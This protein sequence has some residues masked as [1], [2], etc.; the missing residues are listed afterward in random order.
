MANKPEM[1]TINGNWAA[2]TAAYALSEAAA[3]YPIT[4]SSDMAEYADDWASKGQLNVYGNVPTVIEM[5]SEAGA[6]GTLHGMLSGGVLGTTFTASQGLLL[7]IPNMYKMVGELLPCVI[8]VSARSLASHALSIF[9]DH[10]DIYSIR[11]TGFAMLSSNSVQEVV[12]LATVAHLAAVEASYPFLHFFD[13]FR[14]SH[15][16]NKVGI[17]TQDQFASLI[18]PKK[19]AEFKARALNP[20]HP[21]QQ[22]TAQNP[23]TYF[24]NREACNKHVA[25]L[26]SIV[27][28]MMDKVAKVTGRKYK[29]FDY[30]GA[31][32]ATNVIIAMGSGCEA[33]DQ[34]VE[35]LNKAG[36]KL[37]LIKV[38]LYRPFSAQH[39]M[40][41]IPASCQVL[42]ILDRAKENG[43]IGEPLYSDVATALLEQGRTNLK[44]LGG[45][46]GLS[47]KEF[48]PD[49][50]A[51][52]YENAESN[53]PKNHFSVGINDDV[54]HNSL[55]VTA[56]PELEDDGGY[57]FYGLGSDG[58]VG[59]NRNSVSI[60][61]D[62]TNLYA[63]AYFQ[64][65]S[66][67][68]GSTTISHL[69]F[70][71]KPIRNTYL[72]KNPSFVACHNQTFLTR[73]DMLAGIKTG[74][75]FLLNTTY[76]R[77]EIANHLPEAVVQ[78]LL[79]KKI[80][81]YIINAYKIAADIGMRGRVNTIMQSAFFKLTNVIPYE[82]AK[83]YMK[84]AIDKSYGKKGGAVLQMNYKAVDSADS[85]LEKVSLAAN[86]KGF[87][88]AVK[89]S[90]N[91]YFDEF[92]SPIYGLKGNNLPVS[93]F[94]PDG[95]VP[96]ATSQYEK[97][98]IATTLPTWL[99]EHCIQCNQCALVCPHGCLRPSLAT[100]EGLKN[101][102]ETF[103]TRPA[104][105][106]PDKQYRIQL[107]PGDCTGCGMCANVCPSREKALVME[108]F[109]ACKD[110]DNYKFSLTLPYPDV[111]PTNI[112]NSQFLKPY[113]EFSGACAGCGETPYIKLVSQ[114]F[115]KRMIVAN[116]TGCTSI[117]S[118][119]SP[120]C[121][122][123]T[124]ADGHGPAWA[125]SLFE[126][127]AE[128]GFGI[129]G[130][131]DIR[132]EEAKKRVQDLADNGSDATAKALAKAYLDTYEDATANEAATREMTAYLKTLDLTKHHRSK[133]ILAVA[134]ALVK[135]SIWCIGG[136]GWAYDIGFGGLDHVIANNLDVNLLV[137][138][139]EVYSNTG[140]QSSK[141]TPSGAIAKFAAG[142]KPT[143]KKDL[144]AI[145]M[146]YDNVYIAQI[147][148]GANMA[149]TL[150]ALKEA[151]AYR[152][153]SL[154]IAYS[155]CINHGIDMS[156]G[157][158]VMK[159]AVEAGYWTLF[160]R[161]AY[162]E[163]ILDSKEPTADYIEFVTSETRYK[164]LEG[165]NPAAAKE[166]FAQGAEAA[167]KRHEKYIKIAG[168]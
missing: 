145:A 87:K 3:I 58:T 105:G 121:P 37:G 55:T 22:G 62:N 43:A 50:V 66:K 78:T 146:N 18:N 68:S 51:A 108:D 149:Q 153:P 41:A 135:K 156:Q 159:N 138:D 158:K 85:C 89:K 12:D 15:E 86:T 70:S 8:H 60:V 125:N 93:A 104:T 56:R 114:L 143:N 39:L 63:Q 23:D 36:A 117:Y 113:F 14:T 9:G 13:G 5:Q 74:G 167:K 44:I 128:F 95:R 111:T 91:K 54:T 48:T 84:D 92:C 40:A 166:L 80:N 120:S 102:P 130:A 38:R 76:S 133:A 109:E 136:D 59:A 168:K 2:S 72:V 6:A 28:K 45:R 65:D 139:T 11:P 1:Q 33:I 97:R 57:K 77:D 27:Q 90:G 82:T 20:E 103:V 116:A 52:I 147:A 16:F 83:Q 64:Y 165:I 118:G 34:T 30:V 17:I 35:K 24:Q 94:S 19:I 162:G 7:M 151:E 67:K 53:S 49:M 101:A 123:T 75:T 152:G 163:L 141:A 124:D 107:S 4:P 157:M 100:T 99:P 119:S 32:D 96:T 29:L 25:A 122:Y 106:F 129:A 150:T 142:G 126:D 127:N 148:M 155:T 110:W 81:F 73:F 134:D 71:K 161:P 160:R 154:V 140:G 137:L 47:S 31:P 61:G 131:Y 10:S 42:T 21:H 88:A 26:P 79:E 132:R 164:S 69:R 144:G 115:G 112:K 98:D 46:Y